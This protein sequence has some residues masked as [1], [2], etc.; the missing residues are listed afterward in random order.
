[1]ETECEV[2]EGGVALVRLTR[3][4]ARNALNA[5]LR[6]RLADHF[7]RLATD[8]SVRCVVLAGGER[9]FAAGADL[10]AMVD[11]DSNAEVLAANQRDWQP[12]RNFPKPLIAAVRGWALGGG[13]ELAMHADIVVAGE[14]ARFGQPE[15]RVGIMPGAGGTQRLTRAVG[16]VKAMKM[17]LTGEPVAAADA[18]AMGLVSEVVADDRVEERALELAVLIAAQPPLAAQAIKRTVLAGADRPMDEALDMEYAA[19]SAL[20]DTDDQEEG[21]RAFLEKRAPVFKGR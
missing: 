4:E 3:P 11:A 19:F 17:L 16:K 8:E 13:C 7:T 5:A 9:A 20:F 15:I 21:M 14:G 1:M 12:V 18:E 10:T 2:R 6:T